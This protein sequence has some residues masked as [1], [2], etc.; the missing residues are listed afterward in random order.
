M[1]GLTSGA[2]HAVQEH[3]DYLTR[4][5]P[6]GCDQCVYHCREGYQWGEAS[7][8]LYRR[9]HMAVYLCVLT[10]AKGVHSSGRNCTIY[11]PDKR[12]QEFMN[13]QRRLSAPLQI[14]YVLTLKCKLCCWIQIVN[15]PN[16]LISYWVGCMAPWQY[17]SM[18]F[19]L[20]FARKQLSPQKWKNISHI[21]NPRPR[22]KAE[23]TA[24]PGRRPRCGV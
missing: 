24:R 15:F 10:T 13:C 8:Y 17:K 2:Q 21:S 9:E 3:F 5:D 23:C 19:L 22:K 4:H 18:T 7:L 16:M 1:L 6:F 11:L 20:C 14:L 12:D